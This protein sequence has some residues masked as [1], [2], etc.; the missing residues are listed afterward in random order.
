MKICVCTAFR[1][2]A[3]Q[4]ERYLGQLEGLRRLLAPHGVLRPIWVEGDS[5]DD[6]WHRLVDAAPAHNARLLACDHGGPVYGSIVHP[7]RFRQLARVA[8]AMW[9]QIPPDADAVV[10][11]DGDLIWQPGTL[12]ALLDRLEGVPAVAPRVLHEGNPGL[13]SGP[14]PFWYDT[15]GF[16]R[17]GVR[18][19]NEP[20]Y[21]PELNGLLLQVDSAGACL[22]MRGSL[23]RGL[24]WREEDLVVGLCREI[25]A[26]GGSVWVDPALTVYHP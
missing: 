6:T 2:A 22:A 1:N 14:G 9:R 12:L 23:A 19:S 3:G 16:R 15:F 8:N 26:R 11:L 5:S 10:L 18:F 20:P 24:I 7:E 13:Y 21:H 17:N 25:Y 4:V